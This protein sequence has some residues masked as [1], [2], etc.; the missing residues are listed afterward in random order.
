VNR[1]ASDDKLAVSRYLIPSD[2]VYEDTSGRRLRLFLSGRTGS[3]KAMP[4]EVA[5]P[6]S[7][8]RVPD[9]EERRHE[10]LDDG[11]LIPAEEDELAAI[12]ARNHNASTAESALEYVLLP[13]SF[14]N[15]GCSYCGQVHDQDRPMD[16]W[17]RSV[18][19]HVT[20]GIQRET[21][22]RVHISWF[23]GEPMAGYPRLIRVSRELTAIAEREGV[24]YTSSMTTNGSLLTVNKLIELYQIARVSV[25][26]ITLDSTPELHDRRRFLKGG[27]T[28]FTKIT[29]VLGTAL[30]EPALGD[31]IFRL[32]TNVDIGNREALLEYFQGMKELGFDHPRV[33]FELYPVH[34]WS[35]DVSAVE[36]EK[37]E[38]ANEEIDWLAMMTRLGLKCML[39]PAKAQSVVC[40][41]TKPSA[42][43]V[44]STG[45]IFSCTEHVLVPKHEAEDAVGSLA[46]S[47]GT[48]RSLGLFNDFDQRVEQAEVP[49]HGCRFF[50]VCGG[51]CP[52][53]WAEGHSPCPSYKL[54]IQ[55]RFDIY[56]V[57]HGL[58][59]L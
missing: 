18:I 49:C 42:S 9:V 26:C 45:S 29:E 39:V 20:E 46:S 35:N 6:L 14:C 11:F 58:R 22:K 2:N 53:H 30:Q 3:F 4:E 40:V 51:A 15:M 16:D 43:V 13:T 41:A 17:E 8:G 33:F 55:D 56:A 32:R 34:A 7:Q 54:N 44:S 31:V 5:E 19:A 52:K 21:T 48:R 57:S 10:L 25:L 1:S 24:R 28:S 23:G 12:L 37:A 50:G 59:I 36:I 47:P 27:G 38:Y